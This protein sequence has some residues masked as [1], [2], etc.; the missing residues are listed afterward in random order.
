ML[1]L[2]E[3]Y[4][5]INERLNFNI[6]IDEILNV[7]G[8]QVDLFNKLNINK[9]QID[10]KGNIED[11]YKNNDF[12]EKLDKHI[13]KKGKLEDTIYDETLLDDNTKLKFFFIYDKSD[14]ELQE[15]RSIVL[16]YIQNNKK[17]NILCYKGN[18]INKIFQKL[19]DITIELT[20][21]KKTY[22]YKTTNAGNNWIMNNVQ[23]ETDE[24]KSEID[25][26]ELNDLIT[27]NN[28]KI[29]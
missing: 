16:Q 5:F 4:N 8:E 12:N 15:P 20:N 6:S 29:K 23:M 17:S 22:L 9:D 27:K 3:Y 18:D 28:L 13:Y 24:M 25:K 2:K 1:Y 11:L 7:L 19:T 10:F 21:G 26:E 14:N